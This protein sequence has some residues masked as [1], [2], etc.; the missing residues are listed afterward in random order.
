M[1]TPG[2]ATDVVVDGTRLYAT[3]GTNGIGIYDISRPNLPDPLGATDTPGQALAIAVADS[4]A[5]VTDDG[6]G[7]HVVD[8]R[9]ASNPRLITAENTAG[10]AQDVVLSGGMA[11]VSDAVLGLRVISF[12]NDTIPVLRDTVAIPGNPRGIDVKGTTVY[13]ASVAAVE[14]VDV[15]NPDQAVSIGSVPMPGGVQDVAVLGNRAYAADRS[16][17]VHILDITDP[18]DPAVIGSLG[19]PGDALGVNAFGDVLFVSDPG[20]GISVKGLEIVDIANPNPPPVIAI[21]DT[22]DPFGASTGAFMVKG[23]LYICDGPAGVEIV[24]VST[25]ASPVFVGN[26]FIQGAV[27]LAVKGNTAYV[28]SDGGVRVLDVTQPL[29]PT[30]LPPALPAAMRVAVRDSLLFLA[31]GLAGV[32]AYRLLAPDQTPQLIQDI[33]SATLLVA[34]DIALTATHAYVAWGTSGLEVIELARLGTAT[35]IVGEYVTPAAARGI[36][37]IDHYAV[38]AVSTVGVQVV[39]VQTPTAPVEVAAVETPGNASYVILDGR[40]AYVADEKGGIQVLDLRDPLHPKGVGSLSLGGTVLGAT[41]DGAFMYGV[42][43]DS[44]LF[45]TRAQCD[46]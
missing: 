42:D 24:N 35:P 31:R 6:I 7:L 23:A 15:T 10:S 11:Y 44:G 8:V 40:T 30:V 36:A 22:P 3:Y 19:T 13:I 14:V 39:D 34:F 2:D 9:D 43:R 41:S 12:V 25:P 27:H 26:I 17:G 4:F 18:E 5:Y 16:S 20:A 37:L 32:S 45:I 33:D 21:R 28:A 29:A 1:A 38:L 46:N